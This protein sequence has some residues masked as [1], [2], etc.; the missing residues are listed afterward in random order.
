MYLTNSTPHSV[1]FGGAGP[2]SFL[3]I[4]SSR[5]AFLFSM[6]VQTQV[7]CNTILN[8]TSSLQLSRNSNDINLRSRE[9]F[10]KKF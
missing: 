1:V 4:L 10:E 3:S 6:H 5:P 7:R 9:A 8:V 2:A